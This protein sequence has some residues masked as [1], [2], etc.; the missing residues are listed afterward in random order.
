MSASAAVW[1]KSEPDPFFAPEAVTNPVPSRGIIAK[2]V[3][4][5]NTHSW[6]IPMKILYINK[7]QMF[8]VEQD[9]AGRL[10]LCVV[11]GGVVMAE[12]KWKW[13]NL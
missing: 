6:C 11:V 13:T 9:D 4:L 3:P 2:P 1:L 10:Y 12:K 5:K 7:Q 8:S